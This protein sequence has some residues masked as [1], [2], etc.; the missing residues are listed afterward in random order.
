MGEE[1]ALLPPP[2]CQRLILES[3]ERLELQSQ[4]GGSHPILV[5]VLRIPSLHLIRNLRSRSIEA[6]PIQS[7]RHRKDRHCLHHLPKNH[8]MK[9]IL[10]LPSRSPRRLALLNLLEHSVL[11]YSPVK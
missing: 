6:A 8:Q 9:R 2:H 11:R 1:R 4:L 7:H 3:L 5:P 10:L